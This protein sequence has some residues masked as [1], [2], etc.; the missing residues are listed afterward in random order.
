M[1][2]LVLSTMPSR[3]IAVVLL[4]LVVASASAQGESLADKNKSDIDKHEQILKEKVA[5]DLQE[6]K[7]K[8]KG[9][10]TNV[11][12]K[13]TELRNYTK[14]AIKS[15]QEDTKANMNASD[16]TIK[17]NIEK[18]EKH[19]RGKVNDLN[20]QMVTN[21]K[22][23]N[24]V[25]SEQR[26]FIRNW[27]DVR[28][29]EHEEILGSHVSLCAYDYGD[30]AKEKDHIV[31]YNSARGGYLDGH[32]SW[33]VP[34]DPMESKQNRTKLRADKINKHNDE[35][36]A[37]KVLNR[38][39]G[40]FQVPKQGAGLYM[41]TFSVTMDTADFN[42]EPSMYE[43][44]KNGTAIAGTKIYSDAG[45]PHPR[46]GRSAIYDTTPASNTIFLKLEEYDEVAVRQ[47]METD[48]PD[49]HVSFCGSLIHLE[50][51]TESPGGRGAMAEFPSAKLAE[52]V[53]I[54]TTTNKT[55]GLADLDLDSFEVT[56]VAIPDTKLSDN[57]NLNLTASD[58]ENWKA[59]TWDKDHE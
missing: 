34:T 29:T 47:L 36:E 54:D 22:A 17:D 6:L 32:K 35:A 39:T 30:Y 46:K 28:S 25:S 21:L 59:S 56:E 7:T 40:K 13:L 38:E 24:K 18:L 10:V 20:E 58:P 43:F 23:I 2:K 37:M 5:A 14:T 52:I 16:T 44:V 42:S 15:L 8:F 9:L 12:S 49:Y 41:F 33:Q 57:L 4:V 1:G 31:T 45:L 19:I 11:N 53:N 51:A 26:E 48:I 27:T 50:K 3:L 55:A